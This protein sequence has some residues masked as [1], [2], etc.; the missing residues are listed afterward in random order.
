MR[1]KK[2]ITRDAVSKCLKVLFG[3]DIVKE[4]DGSILIADH[5]LERIKDRQRI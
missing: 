4:S 2:V 3:K 5:A 1:H